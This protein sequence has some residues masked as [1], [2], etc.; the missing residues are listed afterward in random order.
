MARSTSEPTSRIK[1]TSGVLA[2][3]V[4]FP[5]LMAGIGSVASVVF[6]SNAYRCTSQ[7]RFEHLARTGRDHSFVSIGFDRAVPQ[8]VAMLKAHVLSDRIV[9]G[10]WCGIEMKA[11]HDTFFDESLSGR[12]PQDQADEVPTDSGQEGRSR[13][14]LERSFKVGG[15]DHFR[16]Y[17]ENSVHFEQT[18]ASEHGGMTVFTMHADHQ[19]ADASVAVAKALMAALN[20]DIRY[21][22][23]ANQTQM[24]KVLDESL[25]MIAKARDGIGKRYLSFRRDA[26]LDWPSDGTPVNPFRVQVCSRSTISSPLTRSP[27]R[28]VRL[29]TYP[30]PKLKT[31]PKPKVKQSMR[32]R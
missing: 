19:R 7:F 4:L 9:A 29:K 24:M 28:R 15:L 18:D 6:R 25:A 20:A 32:W 31:H 30:K 5:I 11:F 8:D 16:S 27:R 22:V 17:L 10:T 23:K 26:M 12:E 1:L 13:R 21:R 2:A 14:Y 3:W